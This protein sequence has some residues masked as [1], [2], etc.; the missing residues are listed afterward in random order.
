[1][2]VTAAREK[3][4]WIGV[5]CPVLSACPAAAAQDYAHNAIC[6]VKLGNL[7]FRLL[8]KQIT[9]AGWEQTWGFFFLLVPL[10]AASDGGGFAV[11]QELQS[12]FGCSRSGM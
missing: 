12:F 6:K 5:S 10:S 9:G 1:M 8:H 11:E 2:Q 7:D 4:F 3:K